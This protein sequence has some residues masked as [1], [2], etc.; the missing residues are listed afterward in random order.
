MIDTL[1]HHGAGR[2]RRYQ[3]SCHQR[4]EYCEHDTEHSR[5]RSDRKIPATSRGSHGAVR[6]LSDALR[7]PH[8]MY[9]DAHQCH[10]VREPDIGHD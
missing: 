9:R 3:D 1:Q 6:L 8:G 5:D 7:S 2:G 10:F 4:R